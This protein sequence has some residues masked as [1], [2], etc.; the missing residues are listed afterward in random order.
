MGCRWY[1]AGGMESDNIRQ[2]MMPFS[3]RGKNEDPTSDANEDALEGKLEDD[4][5]QCSLPF[6]LEH[7]FG[8]CVGGSTQSYNTTTPPHSERILNSQGFI[9]SAKSTLNTVD[10]APSLISLSSLPCIGEVAGEGEDGLVAGGGEDCLVAGG[11]E[12]D[13]MVHSPLLFTSPDHSDTIDH[14]DTNQSNVHLRDQ[15]TLEPNIDLHVA[16]ETSIAIS[17]VPCVTTFKTTTEA[18]NQMPNQSNTA[19]MGSST[20]CE[21]TKRGRKRKLSKSGD[22]Y[23]CPPRATALKD[24]SEKQGTVSVLAL[25]VQGQCDHWV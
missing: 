21:K 8:Q 24:C 16:I 20:K 25:V 7:L 4:Q 5:I 23:T 11:V 14:L 2:K 18:C 17:D 15:S 12:E 6:Y 19:I 10:N 9:I 22:K 1:G 13:Q 3:K